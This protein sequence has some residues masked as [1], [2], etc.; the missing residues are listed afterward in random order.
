M[1]ILQLLMDVI[2]MYL[3]G[4]WATVRDELTLLNS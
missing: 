4:K 2:Q 3:T 1:M